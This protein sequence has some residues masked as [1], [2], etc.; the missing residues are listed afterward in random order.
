MPDMK[1]EKVAPETANKEDKKKKEKVRKERELKPLAT[2]GDY[3]KAH[4]DFYKTFGKMN[5]NKKKHFDRK[6]KTSK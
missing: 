6:P 5:L 2:L 1:Q 4:P 3:L